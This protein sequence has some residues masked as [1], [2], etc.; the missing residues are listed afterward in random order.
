MTMPDEPVDTAGLALVAARLAP[1]LPGQEL[2]L[3]KL[4]FQARDLPV[5]SRR[6][7]GRGARG[8]RHPVERQ[9]SGIRIQPCRM[10]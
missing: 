2:D 4:A 7:V 5:E 10:A 1:R 3:G 9:S 6:E 8:L